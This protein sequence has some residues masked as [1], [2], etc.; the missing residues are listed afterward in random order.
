[1]FKRR[2]LGTVYVKSPAQVVGSWFTGNTTKIIFAVIGSVLFLATLFMVVGIAKFL[3]TNLMTFWPES[4]T[5]MQL[6]N[7]P[8]FLPVKVLGII[9]V[10]IYV[11]R[12]NMTNR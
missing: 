11:F 7:K 1:M 2:K 8:I 10:W 5:A 6:F 12:D 9:G 4:M 3:G